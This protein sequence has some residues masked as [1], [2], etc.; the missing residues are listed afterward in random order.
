MQAAWL[1][2]NGVPYSEDAVLIE[3]FDR[4]SDGDDEWF[5]VTTIVEDPTYLTEPFVISSNFRRETE[6]GGWNPSPCRD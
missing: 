4:Y 6:A 3:F 2:P 5:T 1:R